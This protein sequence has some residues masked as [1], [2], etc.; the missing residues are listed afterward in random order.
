[1][2]VM[3]LVRPFLPLSHGRDADSKTL[4]C[5][6]EALQDA[7]KL[8]GQ[9]AAAQRQLRPQNTVK[10]LELGLQTTHMLLGLFLGYVRVA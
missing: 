2:A 9:C 10:L 6:P 1:M 5:T 8:L 3:L 7:P 4:V